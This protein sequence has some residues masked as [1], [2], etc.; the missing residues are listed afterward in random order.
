[1]ELNHA[2]KFLKHIPSGSEAGAVLVGEAD[3]LDHPVCAFVRL[4]K[5]REMGIQVHTIGFNR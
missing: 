4:S 5:G 2:Q 1:M 3:F